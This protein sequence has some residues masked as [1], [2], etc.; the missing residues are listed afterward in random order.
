MM[1]APEIV[2]KGYNALAGVAV[3]ESDVDVAEQPDSAG[4]GTIW[5]RRKDSTDEADCGEA[6]VSK[7]GTPTGL[8][9]DAKYLY[10]TDAATSEVWRVLK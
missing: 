6:F 3:D 5:R 9:V 10:W 4:R 1:S 7:Q 8:A 2:A